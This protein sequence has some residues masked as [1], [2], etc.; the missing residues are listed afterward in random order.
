LVGAKTD[1]LFRLLPQNLESN[2]LYTD[3]ISLVDGMYELCITDSAGDGLEFWAEPQ[4]GDGNLRMFDMQGNLVHAFESDC[5]NGEKLAFR[6]S[7]AFVAD[8][9]QAK[10]AFSLFPRLITDNTELSFVSN[11][12]SKLLVLI[13]VDGNVWEKHEY[14]DV[15]N[16][17]YSYNLS[18]LPIGRIVLE[19]FMDGVSRFKGRLNKKK[20]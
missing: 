5:G 14:Q 15:K 20:S 1:T 2:T 3:T 17:S 16:G 7:S 11:K 13:T 19:A 9:I 8:T 10:Y 18:N 12:S 4:N 6:A